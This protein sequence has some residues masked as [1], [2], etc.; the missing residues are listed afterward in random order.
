MHDDLRDQILIQRM[1]ERLVKDIQVTPADVRRFFKDL[2]Q[3]SI[4]YVPT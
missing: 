4:P 3:D 1:R 2:P